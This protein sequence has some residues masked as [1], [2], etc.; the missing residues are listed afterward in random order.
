ML[1]SIETHAIG[2]PNAEARDR[3]MARVIL[4]Q[5]GEDVFV[6]GTFN[7][8]GDPT[9]TTVIG[10]TAPG[11]EVTVIRGDIVLDA[12]FNRG[13]DV[14]YLPGEAEEYIAELVGSRVILTDVA[15]QVRISIP[16]GTNPNSIVFG[17]D[18]T[19]M[20]DIEGGQ[21]LIGSQVIDQFPRALESSDGQMAAA[22]NSLQQAEDKVLQTSAETFDAD[23]SIG[24]LHFELAGVGGE[25]IVDM[26][27]AP[28]E[29]QAF[30]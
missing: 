28:L 30:A 13:G 23:M 4:Q 24:G 12:S 25:G 19:R 14:I 17:G 11:E 9:D 2:L 27:A 5:A 10:T 26:I 16:V 3:T 21:V 15:S 18:D 1:A 22:L 6:G 7:G 8:F 29:S 20:I